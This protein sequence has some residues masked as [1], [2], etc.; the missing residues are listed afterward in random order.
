MTS[1]MN[2]EQEWIFY[3]IVRLKDMTILND[4]RF[5]VFEAN[6]PDNFVWNCMSIEENDYYISLDKDWD[7][8]FDS[9]DNHHMC[10]QRR[11]SAYPS[12]DI[13]TKHVQNMFRITKPNGFVIFT[14]TDIELVY[15]LFQIAKATIGTQMEIHATDIVNGERV[16][17]IA[18]RK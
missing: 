1:E 8:F 6:P 14:S 12:L 18:F 9:S 15:T 10:V 16:H 3:N 5:K 17:M 2:G 7:T 4:E 13:L 11:I